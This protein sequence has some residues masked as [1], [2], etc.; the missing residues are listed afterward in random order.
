M[1]PNAFS[2]FLPVLPIISGVESPSTA[3]VVAVATALGAIFAFWKKGNDA[4]KELVAEVAKEVIAAVAAE[5]RAK[6]IHISPQPLIV[7]EAKIFVT[8]P[9]LNERLASIQSEAA[10]ENT[11]LHKVVHDFKSELQAISSQG[12]LRGEEAAKT[13]KELAEKVHSTA[14]DMAEV[15]TLSK[16][17]SSTLSNINQTLNRVI[18]REID[19]AHGKPTRRA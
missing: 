15:K 3:T 19:G 18:E 13:I 10:K 9:Q 1:Q 6:G 4:K 12:E 7:E 16:A 2:N 17:T 11:Y 14:V 5:G 8:V